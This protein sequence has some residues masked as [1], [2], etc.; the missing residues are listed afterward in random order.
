MSSAAVAP[1]VGSVSIVGAG[2]GATIIDWDPFS[3]GQDR[4]VHVISGSASISGLTLRDGGFGGIDGGAIFVNSG[5]SLTL[6]NA[7][8]DSSV[9]VSGGGIYVDFGATAT[10]TGS[11]VSGNT[12]TTGGGI[13]N[14]GGSLNVTSSTIS[15]NQA[16]DFDGGGFG[17]GIYSDG[18]VVILNSTVSGNTSEGD[19]GGIVTQEVLLQGI[20]AF[21][22]ALS[23]DSSTV[24]GN[25]ADQDGGG[26][27]ADGDATII[28][29]TVSF[30]TADEGGGLW[31]F[32]DG[33]IDFSTIAT[34]T[35]GEGGGVWVIGNLELWASIIAG[36][37]VDDCLN[38]DANLDS[39][40]S[41]LD[42]DGTCELDVLLNDHPDTDP[43]LGA[44]AA[45]GGPT[46]TRAL[47]TGSPAIDAVV[48]AGVEVCIGDDQR[49]V[50][51]PQNGDNSGSTACD[52]GAYE[53]AA[54][55]APTPSPA[56]SQLPNTRAGEGAAPDPGLL[57][58]SVA[59]LLLALPALLRRVATARARG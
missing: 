9:G 11:T 40:G 43:V 14:D 17:G 6:T 59:L 31:L 37:T 30:N 18:T 49:G 16:N 51:R 32:G 26:V 23:I 8:V 25:I 5:S 47:L 4:I 54:A 52:I 55:V 45:N 39:L 50:A 28:N 2:A 38:A 42:S 10:L 24:S 46:Q 22:T 29:S 15:G 58:G 21:P 33:T 35:A 48:P 44:L 41:N 27:F 56:A 53:V 1:R 19:G 3:K 13:Y 36:N 57:I 12:A 20:P 34:N 7:V